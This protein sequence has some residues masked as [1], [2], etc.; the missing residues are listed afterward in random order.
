MTKAKDKAFHADGTMTAAE[1]KRRFLNKKAVARGTAQV[2][3]RSVVGFLPPGEATAADKRRLRNVHIR[4]EPN[5]GSFYN[6]SNARAVAVGTESKLRT[7]RNLSHAV[8]S[9]S[10]IR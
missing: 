3:V 9:V 5:P 1:Y 6:E 4:Q 10:F 7:G 2:E 8:Q